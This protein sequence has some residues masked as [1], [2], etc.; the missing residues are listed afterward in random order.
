MRNCFSHFVC[1]ALGLMLSGN[2]LA[3]ETATQTRETQTANKP[4]K[5]IVDTAVAAG[6]FQTLVKAINAADL[7]KTLKG[8]GPFTVFAPS[9]AAFKKIPADQLEEI[10]K[11]ENRS[12]L[13]SLLK[14]HVVPGRLTAAQVMKLQKSKTALGQEISFKAQ[15]ETVMVNGAKI[16]K[17]DIECGNGVIHVIDSVIMPKKATGSS[18]RTASE[19][20]SEGGNEG[21]SGGQ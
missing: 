19:S 6:K 2:A 14:F 3:Q 12:K 9:D 18:S 15:G 17:T 16:I 13:Q 21:S 7:T 5:D 20:N 11:P 8:K 10:L 1:L 4:S